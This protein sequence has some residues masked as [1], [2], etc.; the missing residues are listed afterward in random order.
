MISRLIGA[1]LGIFALA[2]VVGTATASVALATA[3]AGTTCATVVLMVA[4]K[5]T[6]GPTVALCAGAIAV[7]LRAMAGATFGICHP[8]NWSVR[9]WLTWIIA[10]IDLVI[11]V[12]MVPH[13]TKY[14]A[15]AV[16]Y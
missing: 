6:F 15:L 4:I 12:I 14:L 8:G 7:G 1:V 11:I 10:I 16:G 3:V 9:I 2:G 5:V 13:A